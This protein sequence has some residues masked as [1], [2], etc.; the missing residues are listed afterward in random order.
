M[1]KPKKMSLGSALLVAV[2]S[3][4]GFMGVATV[5]SNNSASLTPVSLAKDG[6]EDRNDE[7][8]DSSDENKDSD[9]ESKS[10]KK[11][12]EEARKQSERQR[13]ATKKT[14]ESSDDGDDEDDDM[15]NGVKL[16]GDGS[17]D[18][19]QNEGSSKDDD[20][21]NEG[22]DNG[23]FKDRSKTIEKLNEKLT[24]AEKEILEKQAEGVDVTAAL[25]R[26][27]EAKAKLAKVGTAF[28]ANDLESAKDLAQEV[29]KLTHFAKEKDLHD[30]K[31]VAEDVAKISKRIVQAY[32]KIALL[33]AVGGDGSK[34]K[35]ALVSFEA[36]LATLKATIATGGYDGAVME[37]S[38]ETLERKVK[39]VKGSI[40]GAIYALGG[41]DGQYDDDY[42]NETEDVV[43]N[44]R[45]VADIE[46]DNIGQAVRRMA[47][48][49]EDS[50][51]KVGEVVSKIDDRNVV[52][53]TLLGASEKDL[54]ALEQEI[55]DNKARAL[56]LTQ[57]AETMTDPD[58]KTILMDQVAVLNGQTAKL[59]TFINGQRDR[60]SV[61]GWFFHLFQ[62]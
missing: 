33:E 32:G 9:K 52:A 28:D 10:E 19:D 22:E 44:L 36:D 15:V 55:A 47:Q 25:A 7:D 60:L 23:M 62:K 4:G 59:E 24:E 57:V 31:E 17:V 35:E 16:R 39:A 2:L 6:E 26:L 56:T 21:E 34:A 37:K 48:D 20:E 46:D 61:F 18:D 50:A 30:A 54:S 49:Q 14:Y 42:E 51:K 40:E 29:S 3:F 8:K 11:E 53:Q 43:D 5:V 13:E 41:T 45:D 58:I 12:K 27:A 38:L 1:E